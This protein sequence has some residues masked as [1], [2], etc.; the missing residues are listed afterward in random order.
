MGSAA[1][2]TGAD[3]LHLSLALSLR[4]VSTMDILKLVCSGTLE[5]ISNDKNLFFP[6]PVQ[7]DFRKL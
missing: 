1:T 7:T 2:I 5:F 3:P 4:L 6:A